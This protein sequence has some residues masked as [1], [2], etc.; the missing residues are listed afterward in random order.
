MCQLQAD[1]VMCQAESCCGGLG[2]WLN[3]TLHGLQCRCC[4]VKQAC[5]STAPARQ[6][7]T[8]CVQKHRCQQQQGHKQHAGRTHGATCDAQHVT[9]GLWPVLPCAGEQAQAWQVCAFLPFSHT[10]CAASAQLACLRLS[11][12]SC[13]D[14]VDPQT[15]F[16]CVCPPPAAHPPRVHGQLGSASTRCRR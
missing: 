10:C 9:P 1:R 12:L 7:A 11:A 8:T 5:I 6:G 16:V 13:H 15:S 4:S 3:D 14:G 2:L